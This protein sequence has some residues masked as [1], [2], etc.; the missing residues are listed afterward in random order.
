MAKRAAPY[1]LTVAGSDPS[2]GAGIQG[3]LGTI[4]RMG[5]TGLSVITAITAQNSSGFT[6]AEP[7]PTSMVALQMQ[8]VLS[9]YDV[10]AVKVGMVL[11]VPVI[12][13]V[14]RG[15]EELDVP[16]VLDPVMHSTTGGRLLDDAALPALSKHLV[17]R[18]DVVTPNASELAVLSGMKAGTAVQARTAATKLLDRGAGAVAVTGLA[19]RGKIYDQVVTSKEHFEVS[20][21]RIRGESHGGG[22]AYSAAMAASLARGMGLKAAARE[23]AEHSRRSIASTRSGRGLP[24]VSHGPRDRIEEELQE[25]IG[26]FVLDDN[27]WRH[28]PE[29]QTNFVYS[30]ERPRSISGIL[31][32]EGRIVRCGNRAVMAGRLEYGGSRHVA[33]AVLEAGRAHPSIR[34][35]ANIRY[36]IRTIKIMKKKGMMV[37]S[38]DRTSEP[39]SSKSREGSSVR[40]G[41]RAALAGSRDIPD[42]IYHTGDHGKEPMIIIFGKKP[43]D[44]M[45]KIRAILT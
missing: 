36:D 22:C 42:A 25:S 29:C 4:S 37:L 40:W 43:S 14:S 27:A 2:S 28:I 16:V 3:D 17:S 8:A 30:K 45:D 31:G 21:R 15:L 33:A 9:D 24:T 6:G 44:V 18:A 12:R 5:C 26:D 34:S 32:V 13:A 41:V 1:V 19:G 11:T 10:S 7:V 38:Y 35:A 20:G 39:A 23:A